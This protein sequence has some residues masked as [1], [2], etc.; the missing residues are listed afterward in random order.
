M[1]DVLIVFSEFPGIAGINI[2]SSAMFIVFVLLADFEQSSF[3]SYLYFI[4]V[5]TSQLLL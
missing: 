4:I 2:V 1:A 3:L 5:L